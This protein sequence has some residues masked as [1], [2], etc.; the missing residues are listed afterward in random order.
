MPKELVRTPNTTT[1]TRTELLTEHGKDREDFEHVEPRITQL[2]PNGTVVRVQ[3]V[4]HS[5]P[6]PTATVGSA[7]PRPDWIFVF[8]Q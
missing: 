8:G 2:R 4:Q 1:K 7:T 6:H 3:G 5:G